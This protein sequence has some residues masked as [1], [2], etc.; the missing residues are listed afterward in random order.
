MKEKKKVLPHT[1]KLQK[2]KKKGLYVESPQ[3]NETTG[4][5]EQKERKGDGGL[6]RPG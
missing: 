4:K 6:L 2:R 1:L 5:T 3:W